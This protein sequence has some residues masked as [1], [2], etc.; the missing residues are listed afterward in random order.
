MAIE[1]MMIDLDVNGRTT[2][3][4]LATPA[5]GGSHPGVVVLQ[6]WWGL[7]EDI[8]DIADRFAE[9]GYTALAP[10]FYYGDVA[11]EPDDAR[12]YMMS[13]FE[14]WQVAMDTLQVSINA[15][16]AHD[17]VSSEKVGVTGFCMGGG[18]TWHG[19]AKVSGIAAAV[20]FYGGG[21]PMS[22]EEVASISCPIL[23]IFGELDEG[24]S[25]EVAHARAAQLD[26]GGVTH[27]TIIYP[28]A[29]HAFFNPTRD[30]HDPEASADAWARMLKLFGEAVK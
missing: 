11:T 22:E 28:G 15:L 18:L 2:Q 10:D 29:H 6:E 19:A 12:K 25:P 30:I 26:K 17:T 14:N 23:N 20:P 7:T 1:T 27:E 4:H 5:G 8:K 13:L 9:A 21:P 3:G 16:L 24:V